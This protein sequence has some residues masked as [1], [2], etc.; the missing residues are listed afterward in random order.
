MFYKFFGLVKPP[1]KNS[2]SFE[3]GDNVGFHV[4]DFN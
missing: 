4:Y 3:L 1:K 2:D